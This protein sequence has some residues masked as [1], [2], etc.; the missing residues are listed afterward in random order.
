MKVLAQKPVLEAQ[1]SQNRVFLQTISN[2][3]HFQSGHPINQPP[4]KPQQA[5]QALLERQLVLLE[6]FH[7]KI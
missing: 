7:L 6:Q 5:L 3:A 2:Y 1:L 4:L